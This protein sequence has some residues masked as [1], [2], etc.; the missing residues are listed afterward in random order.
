MQDQHKGLC[1]ILQGA[2]I[3]L[4]TILLGVSGTIYNDHTL[5][6]SKVLG[7]DST[8]SKK[9]S[10]KLH[11]IYSVN[12]AAKLVHT[13][14]ILSSSIITLIRSEYWVKPAT[15]LIVIGDC[16]CGREFYSTQ[17]LLFLNECG[18]GARGWS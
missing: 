18:V 4:H 14:R 12:Y 3:A 11:V 6:P 1:T 16:L 9:L 2:S 7:L 8:R 13:R 10:S 17:W 15:L 5:E